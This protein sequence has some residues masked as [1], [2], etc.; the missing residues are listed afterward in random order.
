MRRTFRYAC[1]HEGAK[2]TV[3]KRRWQ[4]LQPLLSQL[5]GTAA[6]KALVDYFVSKQADLLQNAGGRAAAQD[7]AQETSSEAQE[8]SEQGSVA[9]EAQETSSPQATAS[10]QGSVASKCGRPRP[11]RKC[12][13]GSAGDLG[14]AGDRVGAR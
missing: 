5:G 7:T 8:I 10:E 11:S 3:L 4:C 6:G 9:S 2:S 1:E 14:A 13:V 12:R